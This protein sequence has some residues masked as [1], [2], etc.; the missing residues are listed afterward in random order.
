M[1]QFSPI[2][3]FQNCQ[4][5][6]IVYAPF[7]FWSHTLCLFFEILKYRWV[8]VAETFKHTV[9]CLQ[10]DVTFIVM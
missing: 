1:N 10:N 2:P 3:G 8:K 9:P 5:D 7:Q 6:S 4:P